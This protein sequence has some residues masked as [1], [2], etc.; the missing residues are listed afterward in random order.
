MA[1]AL[2]VL[3]FKHSDDVIIAKEMAIVSIYHEEKPTVSLFKPPFSWSRLSKSNRRE[4]LYRELYEHGLDWKSG[5]LE[6]NSIF[7]ILYKNLSNAIKIYVNS[8]CKK[9][10]LNTFDFNAVNI[11]DIGYINDSFCINDCENHN[12]MWRKTC[13]LHNVMT[14]KEFI[15]KHRLNKS[16]SNMYNSMDEPDLY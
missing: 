10:W 7:S 9:E 16:I 14:M 2:D 6:F 13:A 1:Y 11:S 3:Y 4:N 15:V 5:T 8:N 12:L